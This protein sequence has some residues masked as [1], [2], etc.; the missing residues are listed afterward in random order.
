MI[1]MDKEL[2]EDPGDRQRRKALGMIGDYGALMKKDNDED[3]V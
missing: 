1:E 2:N 3:D